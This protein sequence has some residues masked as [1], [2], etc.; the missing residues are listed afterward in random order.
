MRDG[1]FI[2]RI[3]RRG[4]PCIHEFRQRQRTRLRAIHAHQVP[5]RTDRPGGPLHRLHHVMGVHHHRRGVI[6][7][8]VRQ[9][10]GEL[11]VY[12]CG[13]GADPPGAEQGGSR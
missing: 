4:K 13:N 7:Q 6:G 9:F 3:D 8:V 5:H 12:Q 11:Y 2:R 10:G 1:G